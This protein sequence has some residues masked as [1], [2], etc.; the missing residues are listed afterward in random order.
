MRRIARPRVN[1]RGRAAVERILFSS[2]PGP[3]S[4]VSNLYLLV[5]WSNLCLME[6]LSDMCLLE[7]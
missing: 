1:T 2:T 5:A 6:A 3:W 7:A 4:R